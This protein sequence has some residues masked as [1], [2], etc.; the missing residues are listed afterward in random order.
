MLNHASSVNHKRMELHLAK[1]RAEG[2][3]SLT[4]RIADTTVNGRRLTEMSTDEIVNLNASEGARPKI[5]KTKRK[6]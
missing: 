1:H 5:I 2:T 4:E 3:S 6:D